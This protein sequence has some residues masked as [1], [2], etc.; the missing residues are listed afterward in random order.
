MPD[1][2]AAALPK[3][4]ELLELMQ[5]PAFQVSER[6]FRVAIFVSGKTRQ[7]PTCGIYV[8]AGAA[9]QQ[10]RFQLIKDN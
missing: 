3:L 5:I 10:I 9:W 6:P 4:V 1:E 2:I 8:L 7:L